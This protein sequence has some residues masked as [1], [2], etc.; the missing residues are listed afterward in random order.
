MPLWVLALM[1]AA[2]LTMLPEEIRG[3]C[4]LVGIVV[5]IGSVFLLGWFLWELVSSGAIHP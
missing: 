2:I 3:Y 5:L 1:L 4:K